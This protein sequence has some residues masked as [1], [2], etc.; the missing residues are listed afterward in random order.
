MYIRKAR[1][2]SVTGHTWSRD[3]EVLE[4][5]D[6]LA[7]QLLLMPHGGFSIAEAPEPPPAAQPEEKPEPEEDEPEPEQEQEEEGGQEQKKSPG[8]PKL[9]RDSKG[10][11]IRK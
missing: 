2:G 1:A 7:E 10:N 3:G 9:P 6:D 11:I 4:I 8:R 5:E